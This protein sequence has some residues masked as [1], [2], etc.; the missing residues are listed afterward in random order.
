MGNAKVKSYLSF[1]DKSRVDQKTKVWAIYNSKSHVY[2]GRIFWA[3]NFRAYAFEPN[4][5]GIIFDHSCLTEVSMFIQNSNAE[6]KIALLKEKVNGK[7]K[8]IS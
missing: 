3:T 2:L 1:I 5:P 8:E 6:H 7:A 4:G